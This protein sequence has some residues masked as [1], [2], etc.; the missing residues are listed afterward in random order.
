MCPIYK[1]KNIRFIIYGLNQESDVVINR[2]LFFLGFNTSTMFPVPAETTTDAP[3][4]A[5][6][7]PFVMGM[8]VIGILCILGLILACVKCSKKGQES[9]RKLTYANGI[10]SSE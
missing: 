3:A 2:F 10:P 4:E 5:I 8:V 1:P 6:L 9:D 7:I